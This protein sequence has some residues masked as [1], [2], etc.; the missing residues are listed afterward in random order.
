MLS[1]ETHITCDF[2]EGSGPP[3]FPSGSTHVFAE[4]GENLYQNL[5]NLDP[6]SYFFL[7]LCFLGQVRDFLKFSFYR[8]CFFFFSFFC[9]FSR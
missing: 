7:L 8:F 1:I 6:M 3:I 5:E 9:L 2:P 4:P